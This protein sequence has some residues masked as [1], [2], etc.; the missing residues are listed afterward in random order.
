MH[1]KPEEFRLRGFLRVGVSHLDIRRK[2]ETIKPA[3]IFV[4]SRRS[5][6]VILHCPR[7]NVWKKKY[8]KHFSRVSNN[9]FIVQY[10]AHWS[11]NYFLK[12]VCSLSDSGSRWKPCSLNIPGRKYVER[13][14][15]TG[16]RHR[17]FPPRKI[18]PFILTHFINI[19][20]F[21]GEYAPF[22]YTY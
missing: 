16:Y 15:V 7:S 17:I 6:K 2:I 19:Q 21:E 13:M 14:T 4:L 12:F 20:R 3:R 9:F 10:R 8:L 18:S 1:S 11:L 22:R 5:L